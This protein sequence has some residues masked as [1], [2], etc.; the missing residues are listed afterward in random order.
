MAVQLWHIYFV[1]NCQ[2]VKPEPK[3]KLVIPVCMDENDYIGFLINSEIGD[4]V[5]NQEELLVCQAYLRAFDHACLNHDSIVACHTPYKFSESE[6]TEHRHAVSANAKEVIL[7]AVK[8]CTVIERKYK[9]AILRI[10]E[11]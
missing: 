4:F 11:E 7:N 1:A 6:L 10:E 3:D 9:R 5:R 8:L 2:Y